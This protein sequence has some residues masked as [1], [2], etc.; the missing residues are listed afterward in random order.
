MTRCRK[1]CRKTDVFPTG[2]VLTSQNTDGKKF[3]CRNFFLSG[4][5][6]TEVHAPG[7]YQSAAQI[8]F[9]ARHRA[10]TAFRGTIK[11]TPAAYTRR[12]Y[13]HG[14]KS[15]HFRAAARVRKR[16]FLYMEPPLL[17]SQTPVARADRYALIKPSM[18]P[19]ITALMLAFSKPVRVSF[20]SVYGMKT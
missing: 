2:C 12:G 15:K 18:S 1:I 20:A 3:L 19:S 7:F 5:I 4:S 14:I 9:Y 11:R 17:P 6:K 16:S 8:V 13:L 10:M